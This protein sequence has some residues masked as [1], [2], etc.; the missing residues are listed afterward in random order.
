[1]LY[2]RERA[3]LSSNTVLAGSIMLH[4][5]LNTAGSIFT[6]TVLAAK[7]MYILQSTCTY[8]R[9]HYS[10][11]LRIPVVDTVP[12]NQV[13]QDTYIICIFPRFDV[14]WGFEVFTNGPFSSNTR[15]NQ[16]TSLSPPHVILMLLSHIPNIPCES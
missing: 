8:Y 2:N 7:Y 3:A 10:F 14:F 11:E 6:M 1:M 13:F 16:V 4:E 12:F 15:G 9:G 5:P